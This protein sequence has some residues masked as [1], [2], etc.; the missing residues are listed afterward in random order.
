MQYDRNLSAVRLSVREL[1]EM[2][3]R[4]GDLERGGV[5]FSNLEAAQVGGMLHRRLQ[6]AAGVHY[7]AEVSLS[8]TIM[9][10]DLLFCVEG[11]ADGILNT[12]PLTVD[13]IKTF[14]GR[15]LPT[16]P[17]APHLAQAKCYAALLALSRD[18]PRVSTRLTYCRV[19]EEELRYL[20]ATHTKEEL[21][22][23]L[24]GLLDRVM[25]PARRIAERE[26]SFRPSMREARF[27]YSTVRRGQDLLIKECYR[28][29]RAGKRLFAEAPTGLGKTLSTLYPAVRTMGEGHVDRIFYL[30]AKASARREALGAARQL[31]RGGV[32]LPTLVLYA[33]ESLC[34]YAPA[35]ADARGVSHY[36]NGRSCPYAKGFYDRLE[37]AMC[38]L[39]EK[40]FLLDRAELLEV[41]RAHEVCPYELQ[42]E[43]ALLCDLLICDYNYVFDPMVYLRRFLDKDAPGAGRF[44]FLIDE[45]HNLVDRATEAYSATLSLREVRAAEEALPPAT[46]PAL[47]RTL[48]ALSG[49]LCSLR[50]LC[51]EGNETD[52][53]GV[54]HGYYLN[55]A[56]LLSL[57]ERAEAALEALEQ[58]L[59]IHREEEWAIPSE[60]LFSSLRRFTCVAEYFDTQFLTFV[61]MEGEELTV[62]LSCLDPSRILSER[63]SKA[64][65]AVLFS[66]TLRPS[67]YFVDVLGGGKGAP[68]LSLPSP[69][70]PS[71]C[72]V[73]A[74][75]TVSTRYGD[76]GESYK[77]VAALIA[78]TVSGQN[79]NYIVYFPS[80][81]YL[82][83]VA[84][85]FSKRYPQVPL[86]LQRPGMQNAERERFLEAFCEDGRLRVGFCVLGGSFSEGVD[87][88]GRRL[89]GT[90]IVGTGLP[91]LSSERNILREYYDTTR[92]RGFDYAYTY[93]GWNRVLQAAGR[94]IRCEEDRG[95]I[96]LVDD[97]YADARMR[98]LFPAHWNHLTY[99]R[100]PS[101]LAELMAEFWKKQK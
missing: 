18:L 65:A 74:V 25:L 48:K 1:C 64:H 54:L 77:K 86:I 17:K 34:L 28:D 57:H 63:L 27:P 23:F 7:D 76:R 43:M 24:R 38:A 47:L 75:P 44:V 85:Q 68:T 88:P 20:V 59:R 101:E 91:G 72:A 40:G 36:C 87:L 4:S 56:P 70:D 92:E 61:A 2:A 97:R 35:R 42:L 98:T 6:R 81:A 31:A 95:V 13:E 16:R 84:A 90:L 21:E 8:L 69:F 39:A 49:A 89:I 41:A 46:V 32:K 100:N 11:R 26:E 80:Y 37:S 78:A 99:A 14:K 19:E 96:V 33:K 94:V 45:A 58:C 22:G 29:I 10:R 51:T 73:V 3:L 93:P 15:A 5:P 52:A 50:A 55:R 83:A 67:D 9:H 71:H 12:D 30:T 79:G 82:E 53:E 66:A 60:R 62:R